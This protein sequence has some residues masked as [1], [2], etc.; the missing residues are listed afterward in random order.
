MNLPEQQLYIDGDYVCAS[1]GQVFSTLNPAT[2]EEICKVQL[3]SSSDLDRAVVSARK[4][5]EQ[6]SS[7]SG[8]ERSRILLRAVALLRERNDEL[9]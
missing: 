6:W 7:I 5:F 2:G 4:G 9:A 1:S 8:T 3:A